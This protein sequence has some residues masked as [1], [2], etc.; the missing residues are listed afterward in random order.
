MTHPTKHLKKYNLRPSK[1]LG[2]HFLRDPSI[3]FSI[4]E[5]A[6][7]EPGDTVVEVGPGLGAL[8][9]FLAAKAGRVAAVEIDSGLFSFLKEEFAAYSN[10]E[11][12]HGDFLKYDLALPAR[13]A[14]GRIQVVGNLPYNITSPVLF[15]LMEHAELIKRATLM[16]QSEVA[17]RILASPG[18]REY[19]LLSVLLPYHAAVEMLVDV[20]PGAFHPRPKVGSSVIS[21]DFTRPYHRRARNESFFRTVVK[22]S[23]SMRRKMVKN[24][25]VKAGTLHAGLQEIV[26]ALTASGIDP[27]A[28]AETIPLD[29]FITL[30]DNLL[31]QGS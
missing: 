28:R 16:V 13:E 21:V 5:G 31:S 7:V 10:V 23:F 27:K 9:R 6:G 12:I 17:E 22:A 14:G 26:D 15:K 8:T 24:G 4:V 19:G 18:G 1:S 2:Q 25:L 20:P 30:S 3:A 11:I 29:R